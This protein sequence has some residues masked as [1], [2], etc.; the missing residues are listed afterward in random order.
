VRFDRTARVS[1]AATYAELIALGRAN[2]EG[3]VRAL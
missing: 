1:N 2:E 3:S